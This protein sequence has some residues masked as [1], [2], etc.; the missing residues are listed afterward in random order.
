MSQSSIG[1]TSRH[2]P[3]RM[4]CKEASQYLL[5]VHGVSLSPATL[6]KLATIGGSP[7]FWKDGPFPV[8]GREQLDQFA[9]K[10]LGEL[11]SSTSSTGTGRA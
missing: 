9:A 7:P 10:R 2:W 8:Y 6:A 4:R 11:R 3:A 5:D 1:T